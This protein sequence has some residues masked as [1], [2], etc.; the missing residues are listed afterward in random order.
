MNKGTLV[1]D[2]VC[3]SCGGVLSVDLKRQMYECPF[4]GVTFDYDYFR[5]E[6]VLGIAKVA[7]MSGELRS[8]RQAYEFM[9]TKE[10]DNFAALRGM[11]LLTM[12]TGNVNTL[13]QMD[14]YS[15]LNCTKVIEAVDKAI[16]ASKPEHHEYFK[17]MKE[18]VSAG[19]EYADEGKLLEEEKSKKRQANSR[20]DHSIK[21][22]DDI[23]LSCSPERQTTLSPVHALVIALV[24]VMFWWMVSFAIYAQNHNNPYSVENYY[25]SNRTTQTAGTGYTGRN[26]RDISRAVRQATSQTRTER[27][28]SVYKESTRAEKSD[29]WVEEHQSDNTYL[30]VAMVIPLIPFAGFG[31]WLAKRQLGYRKEIREADKIIQMH[32]DNIEAHEQKMS[33]LKKKV[34][35][36]LKQMKKIEPLTT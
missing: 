10:P 7:A 13:G 29:E 3:P 12:R 8:A 22:R 19:K 18:A 20:R 4:C 34:L 31:I 28:A 36:D 11:A 14:Q 25:Q 23:N 5:E 17:T 2:H 9:L 21:M 35:A 30:H 1:Q 26:E 24:L 15:K 16:E 6:S 33:E 32:T 27:K